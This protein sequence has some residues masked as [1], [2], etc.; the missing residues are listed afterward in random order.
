M[1]VRDLTGRRFGRFLVEHFVETNKHR[2]PVWLCKCRCGN[3]RRIPSGDLVS[4]KRI[5]CGCIQRERDPNAVTRKKEYAIYRGII[6][7]CENPNVKLYPLYGGRGVTVSKE[8]RKSFFS[9]YNDM[10]P[11]PSPTHSVERIDP[12][13]NYEK[14]NCVWATSLEQANNKRNTRWVI[15]KG[16]RLSLHDAVRSAGNIIHPEAAWIR[17]SECGWSVEESVE[18]PR[19]RESPNSKNNRNRKRKVNYAR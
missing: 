18:T 19:I 12:N 3:T 7:R 17:I 13:G 5:S 11:R 10:G 4:G 8:W 15:Y 1:T 9:F 16:N 6:A 2:Q 14:S